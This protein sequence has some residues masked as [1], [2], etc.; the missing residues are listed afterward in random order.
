[1]LVGDPESG[2][3]L[4]DSILAVGIGGLLLADST[5]AFIFRT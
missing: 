4:A 5:L 3:P 2:S 1:M